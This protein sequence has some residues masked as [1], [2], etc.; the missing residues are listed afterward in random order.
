MTSE[1]KAVLSVN[2]DVMTQQRREKP[3]VFLFRLNAIGAEFLDASLQMNR[4]STHNGGQQ[5]I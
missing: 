1:I 2:A 3:Q 5:Q 4:I